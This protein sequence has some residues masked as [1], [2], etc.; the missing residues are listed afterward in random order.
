M[1]EEREGPGRI[2][3]SLPKRWSL[4]I[5]RCP[6]KMPAKGRASI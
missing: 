4:A 2:R 1:K 5:G 3:K 6:M